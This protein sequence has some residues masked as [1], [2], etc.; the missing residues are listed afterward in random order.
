MPEIRAAID[1]V[2]SSG[3]Y[4]RGRETES[5]EAKWADFCGQSYCVSCGSGTDALTIAAL[6][7]G[8]KRAALQANTLPLTAIGLHRAS[9]EL[10]LMDV[11]SDGRGST[12]SPDRVPVLLY[13]RL[14]M[15]AEQACR[16]YDAAHAHGWKPGK[17]AVACWSFYPSKTLGALGDAGAVTTNDQGL[18]EKMRD[19]CGRD[20]VL[21]DGRQLTSRM[22]EVQAAVLGVKLKSLPAWIRERQEIGRH[23]AKHLPSEMKSVSDAENDLQHLAVIK[24]PRREELSFYLRKRGIETKVHFPVPLHRQEAP[25]GR[26]DRRLNGAEDWCSSVLSLP[27]F[28][29]M[30]A[31]ELSMVTDEATAFSNAQR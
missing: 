22:D 6:A 10:D 12:P 3:W 15:G 17:D 27:C 4:L 29:G 28:P 8:L 18:A 16:L 14:P 13:G 23:Y 19:L 9:V 5:F 26:S 30:T 24:F 31:E 21:R 25:W 7:L 20:D 11:S 1:R 2:L